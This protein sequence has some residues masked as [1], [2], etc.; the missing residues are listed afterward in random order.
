MAQFRLQGL[1]RFFAGLILATLASSAGAQRI[2]DLPDFGSQVGDDAGD[3][4]GSMFVIYCPGCPVH[5]VYN[6]NRSITADEVG[7]FFVTMTQ[8]SLRCAEVDGSPSV[9]PLDSILF[10][11]ADGFTVTDAGNADARVDWSPVAN[12][13]ALGTHTTGNYVA[14]IA[15]AGNATVTVSGSGSETAAVTLN[16]IDVDCTNCLGGTEINEAGLALVAPGSDTEVM[17]NDGGAFGGDGN[18]VYDKTLDLLTVTGTIAAGDDLLAADD[19]IAGGEVSADTG[20]FVN[21]NCTD[22]INATEIEDIYVLRA[23]NSVTL[24]TGT[25]TGIT[26]DAG[27]SDP[28]LVTGDGVIGFQVGGIDLTMQSSLLTLE[29]NA[30]IEGNVVVEQALSLLWTTGGDEQLEFFEDSDNGFSAVQFQAPDSLS[31]NR[32]CTFQD[33]A[34]PIPDSCVGDGV[35]DDVPEA[36]DFDNLTA[37]RSLTID[38]GT[39]TIDADQEL[40]EHSRCINIDPGHSTTDWLMF[41]AERALTV[42]GVDCLVDAATSVVLTPRECDA[43]GANCSDIEAAITCGTTNSTEASGIDNASIDAGDWVRVTRGTLTGSA[44]QA[45]ICLTYTV[46]D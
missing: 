1:Y 22:C 17:F 6:R 18:F 26:F 35:D 3:L 45:M 4:A 41:R 25:A 13:I 40:Y 34:A 46:A 28:A 12:Q 39:G 29:T 19:V 24:G 43:D 8:A 14:T 5:R 44:S 37:G 20:T 38:T 15:D 33:A 27:T 31:A 11:S 10:D 30:L 7:D 36:D 9:S 21:F 23:D 42:I 16:V 2:S 32:S